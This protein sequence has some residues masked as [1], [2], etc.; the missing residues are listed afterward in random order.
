MVHKSEKIILQLYNTLIES[1][2]ISLRK[3]AIL[4]VMKEEKVSTALIKEFLKN[5]YHIEDEITL[6]NLEIAQ[7]N[8]LYN[9]IK[10]K[11]RHEKL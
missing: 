8:K 9:E 2:N 11:T 7:K 3:A 10:I 5:K 1:K 4:Q 6:E